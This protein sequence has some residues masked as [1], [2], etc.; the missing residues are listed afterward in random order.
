MTG[1]SSGV[2]RAIAVA[3]AEPGTTLIVA[4][5]DR[6][7]LERVAAEVHARGARALVHCADLTEDAA[8]DKLASLVTELG[9]ALEVLVHAM[10]V[11]ALGRL[12]S[13]PV[14]QLDWQFRTNVRAPYLISQALLPALRV[15]RGQLVFVN[16]TAGLR[17]GAGVGQYAATKHALRALA[18]SLRAEVNPEGIRVISIYLGQTAT[19]MQEA[20]HESE[21]LIYD[22]SQLIQAEDVASSVLQALHLPRSAEI[23]DLRIR[24]G[25]KP[26]R[27]LR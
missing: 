24:P 5:R 12:E 4:G 3:L 10:G 14:D 2:G 15:R 25:N 22:A 20:V 11:I 21:G 23:T 8:V 27:S 17:A 6:E 18:D 1:A 16:S 7:R 9:S 13:T 19:P 26:R